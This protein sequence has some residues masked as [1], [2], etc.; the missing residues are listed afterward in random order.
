MAI[1]IQGNIVIYDDETVRVAV[2]STAERPTPVTGMLRFNTSD[3]TFEGY[4]GTKWE[5]LSGGVSSSEAPDDWGLIT[6]DIT[7]DE[8]YGSI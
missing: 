6:G 4:D 5:S 3:T 7:S 8:D 2:G 1:K